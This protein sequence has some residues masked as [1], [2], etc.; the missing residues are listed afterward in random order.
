MRLQSP[1]LPSSPEH[2]EE[3]D[4]SGVSSHVVAVA[5]KTCQP[6]A[7]DSP[8]LRYTA[9]DHISVVRRTSSDMFEGSINGKSG[10]FLAS[11]VVF[12]R[13]GCGI[14]MEILLPWKPSVMLI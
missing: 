2:K 8:A 14:P 7:D 6:V 4:Q 11:D 10:V 12:H 1:H 13:G 3:E 5:K 9:G